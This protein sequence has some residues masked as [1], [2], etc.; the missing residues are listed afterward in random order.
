MNLADRV[1]LNNLS[2]L[3][4]VGLFDI[5]S[6]IG[7]LINVITLGVNSAFSPWFFEQLK[8][9][10]NNKKTIAEVT[11][12]IMLLY[13]F[14]AIAISWFSP[15]LLKL[16]ANV[17]YHSA[18]NVVPFIAFAFVINGFYYSFSNVFFLE[19]TKY[20]P[21]ISFIGAIINIALNFLLIPIYGI[22]GAAIAS[23]SSKLIF[24]AIAYRVSQK[25]FY[26]PYRLRYIVSLTAL[27]FSLACLPY[28][29]QNKVD[30]LDLW[31]AI[32]IKLAAIFLLVLPTFWINKTAIM[33]YIRFKV[34]Y[35]N[36]E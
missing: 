31:V 34:F 26:I 12:K 25:L 16:I 23:L 29:F 2:T 3:S 5:G 7:K 36:G 1:I 19:K 15:E 21:I 8:A 11:D 13:V 4:L 33:S 22:M 20:L 30:G 32:G 28:Y 35:K 14:V 18:W 6:Q 9:D 10:K 27:G 24:S 17:S